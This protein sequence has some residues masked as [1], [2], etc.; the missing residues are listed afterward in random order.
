[1][2]H[3]PFIEDEFE[4]A[5]DAYF[6]IPPRR[7]F[8]PPYRVG[9]RFLYV[10]RIYLLTEFLI[11]K[12]SKAKVTH[13]LTIPWGIYSDV[14]LNVSK[15]MAIPLI[16][17]LHDQEELF[18]SNTDMKKLSIIRTKRILRSAKIIMPVTQE[19]AEQYVGGIGSIRVLK[20]IPGFGRLS[21]GLKTPKNT[22][23]LVYAGSLFPHHLPLLLKLCSA[24]LPKGGVLYIIAELDH[25]VV[26][27]IKMHAKNVV[28]IP[29]FQHN[30]D[31]VRFVAEKSA[32]FLVIYA[33][34]LEDQPWSATSYPSKFLD[35]CRAGVPIL[36]FAPER[37]AI[38]RWCKDN[39][40]PTFT[41]N[42]EPAEVVRMIKLV[43]CPDNWRSFSR[44]SIALA[45]NEFNAN[46]IH[47]EF[48]KALNET[49]RPGE[50]VSGNSYLVPGI[51]GWKAERVLDEPE[52]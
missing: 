52:G 48:V 45:K 36:I 49:A 33:S 5:A 29:P 14:A 30:D 7:L 43:S 6:E 31:A 2:P 3:S 38:S 21:S 25:E 51:H 40:W 28:V 17:I 41:T 47:R 11:K 12:L 50:E 23:D 39:N 34:S 18:L 32:S 26:K 4:G 9:V 16:V 37:A 42:F 10:I 15:K 46:R 44:R 22:S 13:I 27:E 24:I 1:V 19:L 20:P 8:W 35:F